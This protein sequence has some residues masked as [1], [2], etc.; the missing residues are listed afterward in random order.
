MERNP[1]VAAGSSL[2]GVILASHRTKESYNAWENVTLS[3]RVMH[4]EG[5]VEMLN[6]SCLLHCCHI[7][8]FPPLHVGG[9][10]THC[11]RAPASSLSL[12][13]AAEN[14]LQDVCI[15]QRVWQM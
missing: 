1:A 13:A 8:V 7:H 6:N 12:R 10:K 5:H 4:S 2:Y 9:G 3:L 14:D 11:D 15:P